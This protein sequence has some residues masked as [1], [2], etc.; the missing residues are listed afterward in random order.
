NPLACTLPPGAMPSP[1]T[2]NYTAPAKDQAVGTVANA[3]VGNQGT[4][5][6]DCDIELP[7]ADPSVTYT[8]TADTAGPVSVG[9]TITYT[10]TATVSDSQLVEARRVTER[11]STCITL[12]SMSINSHF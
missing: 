12:R 9:D 8:K 3:G 6:V 7:V 10:L 5:D 1:Y 4:C 11:E 2:G